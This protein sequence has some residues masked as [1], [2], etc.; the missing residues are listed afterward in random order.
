[1]SELSLRFGERTPLSGED[2]DAASPA[3]PGEDQRNGCMT[4]EKLQLNHYPVSGCPNRI[5][6][7]KKTE[8]VAGYTRYE[9]GLL[10]F[11]SCPR[12]IANSAS[13]AGTSSSAGSHR[14]L[15]F[16]TSLK[17]FSALVLMIVLPLKG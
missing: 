16:T 1:M 8:H 9:L 15:V 3:S 6:R 7:I 4:N 14:Y 13:P 5:H 11:M 10:C 17:G 12:Q 2:E